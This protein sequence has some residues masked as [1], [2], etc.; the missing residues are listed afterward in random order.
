MTDFTFQR[1]GIYLANL[2]PNKGNEPGK[3]RPVLVV[4]HDWLNSISHPTII[5]LPLTTVLFD[6]AHPLR[7]RVSERHKLNL[8]SDIL[9][10]QIRSIDVRRLI[11]ECLTKLTIEEMNVIQEQLK[12]ILNL[13]IKP[14]S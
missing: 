14:R 9:C 4:Q 11:P 13:S 10:D 3:L 1:G 6:D 8:D 12:L 5:V 7:S 2:N